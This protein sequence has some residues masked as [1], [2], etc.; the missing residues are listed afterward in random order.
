MKLVEL[1]EEKFKKYADKHPQISFHQTKEWGHLKEENGWKMHLVGLVDDKNKIHAASLLLSKKVPVFNKRMFYSPRGFLIDYSDYDLL[2]EFTSEVKKYV[3]ANKGIFVKIDPY[4]SYQERDLLGEIVPDG[5]NNKEGFNNLVKLGYKHFGFNKLQEELQPRWIFVTDVYGKTL[6]ELMNDMDPKT[7][8]IL[9]KNERELVKC[10]EIGFDE[11]DKFKEIMQHTGDRRNFIDRPFKYYQDMYK[12]LGESGILKILIAEVNLDDLI[13]EIDNE[14]SNLDKDYKDKEFKYNRDPSKMNKD[15]YEKSQKAI[16]D[17]IDR[18][19]KKKDHNLK[20]KEEN[21]S[22]LTL[23]GI[24]F[25]IYGDEVLS[26]VGGSYDKFME[27]QSAYTV[28]FEGMKMALNNGYKRY[29]FYGITGDF[30]PSNPLFGLYSFKRDFGGKVVELMGEF[31]LVVSK[32]YYVL[33]KVTFKMYHFLK[34]LKV[35][36]K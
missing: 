12:Y 6:E 31:D 26:L 17:N 7:R 29:N 11:L 2:K 13:N 36:R 10:R 19:T 35:R 27:F 9:R 18:L 24:L 32:F 4:V 22:V 16:L 20:L 5:E 25:L 8:Q 30:N 14:I 21:G 33:Y 3:K 23:G 34:N 1:T 28:H 15:K